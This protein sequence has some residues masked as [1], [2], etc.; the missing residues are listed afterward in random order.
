MLRC[1]VG[2]SSLTCSH[3]GAEVSLSERCLLE[4]GCYLRRAIA[5][6][7]PA[8][9]LKHRELLMDQCCGA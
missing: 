5:L 1:P 7:V 9:R 3:G 6:H 2:T 4:V 8:P